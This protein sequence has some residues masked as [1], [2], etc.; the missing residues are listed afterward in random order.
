MRGEFESGDLIA[1]NDFGQYQ[2]NTIEGNQHTVGIVSRE[3]QYGALFG[4]DYGDVPI[5]MCG[6]VLANVSGRCVPGDFLIASHIP[7][8]IKACDADTVP[9]MAICGM[10]LEGKETTE[11]GQILVQVTRG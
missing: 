11:V 4:T 10:A 3:G 8:A 7:G 5:A 9:R 1:I 2:K 6:R